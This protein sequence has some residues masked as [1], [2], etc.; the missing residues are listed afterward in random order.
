MAR[1]EKH[2]GVAR[3]LLWAMAVP[4]ARGWRVTGSSRAPFPRCSPSVG[5]SGSLQLPAGER[6]T[7]AVCLGP[8]RLGLA[9]DLTGGTGRLQ[10][11]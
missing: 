10:S 8:S 11:P 1:H 7:P 5:V 2:Q 9:R 3:D 4:A 6:G